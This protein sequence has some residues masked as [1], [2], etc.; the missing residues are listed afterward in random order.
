[1]QQGRQ[2]H[3]QQQQQQRPPVGSLVPRC[4]YK[5][6]PGV[7]N[8]CGASL[9][10]RELG[11]SGNGFWGCCMYPQCEYRWGTAGSHSA[12]AQQRT[13]SHVLTSTIR[14]QNLGTHWAWF[15]AEVVRP[16]QC[17]LPAAAAAN[18]EVLLACSK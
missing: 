16:H 4:P 8:T 5:M 2:Q 7:F 17:N 3:Q 12:A 6:C 14:L 18:H 10:W 11:N 1:V 13:V 9:H 15:R